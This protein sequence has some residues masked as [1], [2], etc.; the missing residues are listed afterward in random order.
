[1]LLA[2]DYNLGQQLFA[3]KNFEANAE[4]YQQIFE[5]GRRHKIQNPDRMRESYG[6][7]IY[8]LMDAQ[9]PEVQDMLGFPLIN[10]ETPGVHTV[11][12]TLEQIDCLDVLKDDLISTA[13]MEIVAEGKERR[14]VQKEIK[15]KERAVETIAAKYGGRTTR[16]GRLS[17]PEIIRQCLYS[18]GDNHA[19]L[20]VNRDPCEKMISYLKKH[21][22]PTNPHPSLAIHAGKGGARLSHNHEKQYAYV[23]QS[24]TLWREILHDMFKLWGLAEQDLLSPTTT[25]RLRDTGQGL[26]R[27]QPCPRT[28]RMMHSVLNKAQQNIGSWVGSSVIHLGDTAVPNSLMFIDKYS[29][30]YR[31]LLPITNVIAQI[32]SL[33]ANP[34]SAIKDYIDQEFGGTEQLII[35]ILTDVF[36]HAFDG[37][38]ADNFYDAGSCI[39]G[40]LT[41]AWNWC[42]Q[43]EKK[44][45]FPVFLMCGFVG[46]D[47]QW[48]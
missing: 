11:Y 1:L 33:S 20:R 30:V 24:L 12:D 4:F 8:L 31:I 41:S 16:G 32:P 36:R 5:I 19:F 2:A 47:G 40:R 21:F 15:A 27:V 35:E 38:G 29:Q 42:S 43:L 39:D 34:K 25:Y 22:H 48:A 23:L 26:Q 6:K 10:P 17:K 18:I 28:S 14:Q 9:T 3:E 46:F 13:T 7:L 44:R 45:F 37:S